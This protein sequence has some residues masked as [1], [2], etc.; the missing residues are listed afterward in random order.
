MP[1]PQFSERGGNRPD[2]AGQVA[3]DQL[4]DRNSPVYPVL[5]LP[6]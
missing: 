2:K 6:Q 5:S 1:G 4:F 3:H